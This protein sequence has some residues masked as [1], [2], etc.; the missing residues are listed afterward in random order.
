MLIMI[1][2]FARK[3]KYRDAINTPVAGL[4][5]HL[6]CHLSSSA[7]QLHPSQK[8]VCSSFRTGSH[9]APLALRADA[10]GCLG[11]RGGP[12]AG[13]RAGPSGAGP[14][15]CAQSQPVVGV[16]CATRS[17]YERQLLGVRL[18][19]L[20]TLRRQA[21]GSAAPAHRDMRRGRGSAR[22]RARRRGAACGVFGRKSSCRW[23]QRGWRS[24]A[25][26]RFQRRARHARRGATGTGHCVTG[27][28]C[29]G[30][31]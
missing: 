12:R 5:T 1:A 21:P 29:C 19:A 14:G 2:P 10:S 17:R 8:R 23:F 28:G 26:R 18:S 15:G 20:T 13:W 25:E 30:V 31:R 27:A 11:L 4:A 24:G 3:N 16:P 6:T 7:S 22:R 9:G